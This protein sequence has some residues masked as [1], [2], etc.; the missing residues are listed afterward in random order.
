MR[1]IPN[2]GLRAYF[3]W[4][5]MLPGDDEHVAKEAARRFAEPRALHY[6]DSERYFARRM[7]AALDISAKASL[8]DGLEGFA[9][10]VYLAYERGA[11]EIER[12]A[13]WMHQL[14]VQ[15]APRLDAS[16]WLAKV[17][18]LLARP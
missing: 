9:W 11:I 8:G 15:H 14:A 13:F 18:A 3:V 12:P 16:I 7:A 10:D 4:V 6:W 17:Q 1:S 5:P 2:E